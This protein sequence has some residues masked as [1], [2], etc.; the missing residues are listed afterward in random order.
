[1]PSSNPELDVFVAI[2][3]SYIKARPPCPGDAN[4][5]GR[6]RGQ[7][8]APVYDHRD[9]RL[10]APRRVSFEALR[11]SLCCYYISSALAELDH[12]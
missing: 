12:G 2:G 3:F 4:A 5:L 9:T 7:A 8:G 6:D 11:A 10:R 1:M